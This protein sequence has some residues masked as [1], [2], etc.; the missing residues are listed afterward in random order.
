MRSTILLRNIAK[1]KCEVLGS[2]LVVSCRLTTKF[3]G[4]PLIYQHAGA[5]ALVCSRRWAARGRA[6]Y[7]EPV[8]CNAWLGGAACT[9]GSC[10]WLARRRATGNGEY[11][12]RHGARRYVG[13][14]GPNLREGHLER[15]RGKRDLLGLNVPLA[16]IAGQ[17]T[18]SG[19]DR[20]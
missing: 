5:P 3:S 19:Q 4:R 12:R 11:I 20:T 14:V 7:G 18:K 13:S 16:P 15:Q 9:L 8:R 2:L 1:A 10:A 17:A 6:L